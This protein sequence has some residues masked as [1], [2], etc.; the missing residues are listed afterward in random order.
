MLPGQ[1][2]FF[3]TAPST[4]VIGLQVLLQSECSKCGGNSATIGSSSGPHHARLL[5]SACGEHRGWMYGEAYD[6]LGK[7]IDQFGPPTAPIVVRQP[8]RT[9]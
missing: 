8:K 9:A 3:A 2:D 7:Y 5:C 6:F 4:S 1:L